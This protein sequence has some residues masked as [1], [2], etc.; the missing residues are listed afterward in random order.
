MLK[1]YF[2]LLISLLRLNEGA[3]QLITVNGYLKDSITHFPIAGGIISNVNTQKKIATDAKG[4][5]RM[6]ASPND[7]LYVIAPS[8]HYDTITYSYLFTDTITIYLSPTGNVLPTVTVKSQYT[9]YQLDSL[10]RR[11]EFEDSRGK[12]LNTVS[13]NNSSAFGIGINLDRIFKKRYKYKKTSEGIHEMLEKSAYIDYRFSPHLVAYYTGL[14][15]EKL[16][17]FMQRFTPGYTWLRQHPTN[18]DVMYY[19][20]D[21]LK[22]YRLLLPR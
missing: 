10:K 12:Q 7:F 13:S 19:I 3:T 8:Y 22:E 5:F 16:Q 11:A 17:S 14:K 9:K 18:E 6:E 4:F 21:K 15:G 1:L 2:L 20:N